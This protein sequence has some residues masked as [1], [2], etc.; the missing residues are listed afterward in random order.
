MIVNA[1]KENPKI[2]RTGQQSEPRKK[3]KLEDSPQSLKNDI[4]SLNANIDL[5][6]DIPVSFY[7]HNHFIQ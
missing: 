6:V 1:F 3:P 2:I 7:K 5:Y 4:D